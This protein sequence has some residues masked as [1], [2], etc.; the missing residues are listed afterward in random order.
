VN[1]LLR[2]PLAGQV[3]GA[4]LVSRA[5]LLAGALTGSMLVEAGLLR[6]HPRYHGGIV[7]LLTWWDGRYYLLIGQE[8]YPGG[9]PSTLH[10]F[11]PLVPAT[12]AVVGNHLLPA[13]I[14]ANLAGLA[15]IATV[16]ALTAKLVSA[17]AAKRVAWL[18]ALAPGAITLGMTYTE[19]YVVAFACGAALALLADRPW[20]ALALGIGCGLTRLQGFVFAL[21]LLVIA[22]RTP[23]RVPALIAAA[24][25]LIGLALFVVY[26]AIHTG[27]WLAY[28]HAQSNSSPFRNRTSPGPNGVVVAV[29]LA[30]QNLTRGGV[31]PWEIRDVVGTVGYGALLAVAAWKRLPWA[32]IVAGGLAILI[33][34]SAGTMAGTSRYA[35]MAIPAFWVL[36][37]WA[38]RE[39]VFVAMVAVSAAL[40]AL[41]AAWLPIHW[42]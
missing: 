10:G 16:T 31:V 41:N 32:W 30:Y 33:P 35:L 40:M 11:F 37:L 6:H 26:L 15:A 29:R 19:P 38:R 42:P 23:R 18:F 34:V 17:E 36:A 14:L 20:L 28:S 22:L 1:G 13:L 8:G 3:V 24:G 27:D 9:P 2:H 21:P 7:D 4:W 12:F 25:P 39:G 5:V